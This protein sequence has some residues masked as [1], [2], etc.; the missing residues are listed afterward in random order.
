MSSIENA[1]ATRQ[2]LR[3]KLDAARGALEQIDS[4]REGLAFAAH[5]GDEA[6]EKKLTALNKKRQLAVTDIEMIEVAHIEA[7]R[8]VE[9][10][11]RDDVLREDSVKAARG[12]EIAAALVERGQKIDE[13]LRVLAEEL[14]GYKSDIDELNFQC[15]IS[16]PNVRQFVAAGIRVLRTVIAF[17]PLRDAVEF[18]APGE[19]RNMG[20]TSSAHADAIARIAEARMI[21]ESEEAAA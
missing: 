7:S 17:T 20:E 11:Q 9:A 8:R 18:I 13:A 4:E 2:A 21:K 3:E 16:V 1:E 12:M 5:T 15:G 10:A 14:H 6:A 19:R